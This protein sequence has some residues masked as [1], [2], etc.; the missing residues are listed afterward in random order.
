MVALAEPAY[1]GGS[2]S[3][4]SAERRNFEL[5]VRAFTKKRICLIGGLGELDTIYF[6]KPV[7]A[8]SCEPIFVHLF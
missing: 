3:S 6:I 5:A 8:P 7:F 2:L 1:C 4:N